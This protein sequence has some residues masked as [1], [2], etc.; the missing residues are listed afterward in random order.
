[1]RTPRRPLPFVNMSRSEDDEYFCD[2]MTEELINA[3]AQVDGLSVAAR[4][5]CFAYC[6]RN[7]DIR[8]I[9]RALG[10][11]TVL[12]GSVRRSGERLRVTVQLIKV[13][14]GYHL[15]SG[16][17]DREVEDTF[18]IQDEIAEAV[19]ETLTTGTRSSCPR[20][21]GTTKLSRQSSR[22]AISSPLR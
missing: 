1:M 20:W 3:L 2:G 10:V 15:W 8:E 17:F 16:T 7:E 14:D 13:E 21:S 9:G 6:G 4:T 19:V 11:G 22:L 12:E 18:A 5:S